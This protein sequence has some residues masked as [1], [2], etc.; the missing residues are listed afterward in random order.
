MSYV[1]HAYNKYELLFTPHLIPSLG[2][3]RDEK[4]QKLVKTVSSLPETHHDSLSFCWMMIDLGGC[5]TCE[6]DSYRAQKGCEL[7]AKQAVLGFKGSDEQLVD[8]FQQARCSVSEKIDE[9]P[10]VLSE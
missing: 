4:W 2:D 10:L 8:Q 9:I 5:L 7:C 6:M 1:P 3:L